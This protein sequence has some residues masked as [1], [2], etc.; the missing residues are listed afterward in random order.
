MEVAEEEDGGC[1]GETGELECLVVV[2]VY[3][4]LYSICDVAISL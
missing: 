3:I 1:A 4:P 2:M